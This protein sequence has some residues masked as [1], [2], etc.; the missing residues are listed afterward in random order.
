MAAAGI[1][2]AFALSTAAADTVAG[3]AGSNDHNAYICCQ[4]DRSGD[5]YQWIQ[6]TLTLQQALSVPSQVLINVCLNSSSCR[7]D[8]AVVEKCIK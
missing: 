1:V 4:C 5:S 8:I 3:L 7:V 6:S 2:A